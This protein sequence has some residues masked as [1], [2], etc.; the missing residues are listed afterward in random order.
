MKPGTPSIDIVAFGD[1]ER[2]AVEIETGKN[3]IEQ[4]IENIFKC[5]QA[6][7]HKIYAIAT[8]EKA[9][10]KIKQALIRK[11]LIYDPR[12]KV[13]KAGYFID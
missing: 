13:I 10:Q 5:I 9:Y 1:D 7:F 6:D 11:D 4:I 2:I 12:I 3:S 8:T